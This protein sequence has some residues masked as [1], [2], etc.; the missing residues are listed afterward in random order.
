MQCC[1]C[2]CCSDSGPAEDLADGSIKEG[3]F[4]AL[5]ELELIKTMICLN[6][7]KIQKEMMAYLLLM[8]DLHKL[9]SLKNN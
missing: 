1:C 2:C 5:T 3:L 4:C 7:A 9:D 6:T 8:E